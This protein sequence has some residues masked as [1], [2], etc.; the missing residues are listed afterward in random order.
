MSDC[1]TA[2]VDV[3]YA[4]SGQLLFSFKASCS[5][6]PARLLRRELQTNGSA[7]RQAWGVWTRPGAEQRHVNVCRHAGGKRQQ[8]RHV[9]SGDELLRGLV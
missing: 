1:L 4:P 7:A 2:I 3:C 5:M 6:R 9:M 8:P